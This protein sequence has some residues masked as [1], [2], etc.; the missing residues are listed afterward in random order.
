MTDSHVPPE[1]PVAEEGAERQHRR[2]KSF[3]MR[4]GR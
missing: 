3:V 1:S 4:A 2:I